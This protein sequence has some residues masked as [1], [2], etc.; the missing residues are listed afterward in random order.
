VF[1]TGE[2]LSFDKQ[3]LAQ[4]M[5]REA[6]KLTHFDYFE[7]EREAFLLTIDNWERG[8]KLASE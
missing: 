3:Q 6:G 4:I 5:L 7:R 2:L 8:K 1:L